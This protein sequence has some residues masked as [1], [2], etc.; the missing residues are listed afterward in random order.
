MDTSPHKSSFVNVNDPQ[1]QNVRLHYLDWGGS[2]P[3]LLFIPGMGCTAHIFDRFAPRF[4]DKFHV[5]ALTR[6]GHGES[7]YPE[8]GYDADTLAEDLRQFL[9][10]LT[11]D[12]VILAGH[13]MGYIELSRFALLYPE[14]VLK[15]VWIDAAYDRTSPADQAMLARNPAPKMAPPWPSEA[16][17]SI[18]EFAATVRRLYPSLAA[19]WGPEIEADLRA[20]VIITPEGC[21]V[22]KM[23]DAINSALGYTVQNYLPDYAGIQVPMLSLFVLTDG[24]DF[25]SADYM[26]E[27]QKAQVIDYF[28]NDR[29]PHVKNYIEQFRRNVPQ[30]HIVVIPDGN[31]YC[32]LKQEAIVFNAMNAFLLEEQVS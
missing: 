17:T 6:R 22:E 30:A 15:L 8:T 29:I 14:R 11:I 1:G 3:V 31:H 24:R 10:E 12:R 27:E 26:T 5:L 7:D 21:V 18:E 20:N 23:S 19:I 9:D 28:N 25:L 32:F 16:I 4:T 13:S 2:G